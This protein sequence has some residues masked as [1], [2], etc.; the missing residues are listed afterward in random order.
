MTATLQ[1]SDKS[2]PER[3]F[4]TGRN[5][6]GTPSSSSSASRQHLRAFVASCVTGARL[7]ILSPCSHPF[8]SYRSGRSDQNR[9]REDTENARA[10]RIWRSAAANCPRTRSLLGTETVPFSRSTLRDCLQPFSFLKS[11]C[12]VTRASYNAYTRMIIRMMNAIVRQITMN[13]NF[14]KQNTILP[15]LHEC[16]YAARVRAS[17][18]KCVKVEKPQRKTRPNIQA[19]QSVFS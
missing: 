7:L 11:S 13:I 10:T 6:Y 14:C 5:T 1:F 15:S 16:K 8:F 3:I 19:G 18:G 2:R 17:A 12:I 4:L 9:S